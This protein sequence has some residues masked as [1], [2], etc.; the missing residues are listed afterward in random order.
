MFRLTWPGTSIVVDG[1]LVDIRVEWEGRWLVVRDDEAPPAVDGTIR[2]QG[3]WLSL[4]CETPGE[5]W[6]VGMEAFALAVDDPDDDRGDL[7]PLGFD[8]EWEAPGHVHGEVLIDDAV[9]ALD[10]PGDLV[11]G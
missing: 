6:S 8:V 2:A 5:H 4:V 11:V 10:A 7:V 3:L 1:P 9:I